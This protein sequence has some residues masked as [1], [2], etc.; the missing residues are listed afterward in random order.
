MISEELKKQLGSWTNLYPF[1]ESNQWIDLKS[2]LKPDFAQIVPTMDKWFRAFEKCDRNNLKVVWLG[3]SPYYSLDKYR[4]VNVADGLCF[5]TEQ[6]N[7]VPPSLFQLYKG[8][9]NDQ[10]DGMN[11][12]MMRWNELSFLADQGVLLLNSALT[13]IYGSSDKHLEA[14]KPFIKFVINELNKEEGL[15]FCGFGQVAN[16]MLINVDRSK[17]III[18]REHPA[19]AAYRGDYWKH[20]KM[21]T[22][23][24]NQLIKQGKDTI[25]WDKYYYDMEPAPF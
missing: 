23:I 2:K 9:E 10:F 4:K 24:D 3:L 19:A 20:N 18:E 15:I 13:T 17:H 8:L 16:E 7:D 6:A 1:F 25:L 22:E 11:L 5:S 14:W 21:F 12:H